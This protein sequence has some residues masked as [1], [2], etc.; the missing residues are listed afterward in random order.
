M[1][2][3]LLA[4]SIST[5]YWKMDEYY[6]WDVKIYEQRTENAPIVFPFENDDLFVGV[7]ILN[8]NN[9]N[10]LEILD[11]K[12]GR[13]VIEYG[14]GFFWPTQNCIDPARD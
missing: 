10:K 2:L 1:F 14:N 12:Y 4:Y 9:P 8:T 5:V 7:S 3:A 13:F 11:K 6:D